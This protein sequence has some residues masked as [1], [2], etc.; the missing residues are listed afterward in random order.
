[1][2]NLRPIS[3]RAWELGDGETASMNKVIKL[4][5]VDFPDEEERERFLPLDLGGY[6]VPRPIGVTRCLFPTEI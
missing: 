2:S 4:M 6:V 3:D 1:M 5:V